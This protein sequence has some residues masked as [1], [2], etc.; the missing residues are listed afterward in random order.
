MLICVAGFAFGILSYMKLK[1]LPVHQSMRDVSELIYETCK[2]YLVQQGKFLMLLFAFIGSVIFVYFGF[3][4][5]TGGWGRVIIV[6]LFAIIGM[7]GSYGIAWYGIRLNTFANSRTSFAALEG[8]PFKVYDIPMRSGM[9]VGM[10]LISTELIMMLAIMM[11]LPGRHRD[12][13][14]PRLRDR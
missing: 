5:T 8:K 4:N 1:N 12:R 3:L 14:L 6:L 9:S 7:A 11:F 2:A 13:L 10:V